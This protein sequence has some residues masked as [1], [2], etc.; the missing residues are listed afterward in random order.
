MRTTDPSA[1]DDGS[2]S[3]QSP[4]AGSSAGGQ[5]AFAGRK[6]RLASAS[7]SV[8]HSTMLNELAALREAA[9]TSKPVRPVAQPGWV[10]A[11]RGQHHLKMA[12][13]VRLLEIH[14][15]HYAGLPRLTAPPAR[16]SRRLALLA[17]QR[18][19]A[20]VAPDE[21]VRGAAERHRREAHAPAPPRGRG[22]PRVE[23]THGKLQLA[24][25]STELL[26]TEP[27]TRALRRRG[28][29]L[30]LARRWLA[31]GLAE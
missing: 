27:Q 14:P 22:Q 11:R 26:A 17:G 29:S 9:T 19:P 13:A 25:R 5:R 8:G 23:P 28:R 24:R 7:R 12:H 15:R 16:G 21:A 10:S 18:G 30:P 2:P 20:R 3:K 6:Q 31:C 4:K 1:A